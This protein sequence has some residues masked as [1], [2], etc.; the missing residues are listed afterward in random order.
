MASRPSSKRIE[1]LDNVKVIAGLLMLLDHTLLYFEGENSWPRNTITRAVEPLYVFVFGYLIS[2]RTRP[3]SMK[4]WGQLILAAIAETILHSHRVGHLH[5]G[6]LASLA[7]VWPLV[8]EVKRLTNAA[9]I[10]LITTMSLMAILP[11]GQSNFT[12]DYGPCLVLSQLSLAVAYQRRMSPLTL[13]VSV[14]WIGHLIVVG[15][16]DHL[17]MTPHANVTSLLIGHPIALV[18]LV[19]TKSRWLI[20]PWLLRPIATHPLLFYIIHLLLLAIVA[21]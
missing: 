12:I 18:F 21:Q 16:V 10:F 6:I 14:L 2:Y 3:P 20:M 19:A 17:G 9:L 15:I 1:W 7:F 4:R 13:I 8:S 11:L 5:F